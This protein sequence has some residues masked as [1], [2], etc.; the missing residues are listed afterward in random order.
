MKAVTNV[1]IVLPDK[2]MRDGVV[3]FD[4]EIRDIR[5]ISDIDEDSY[6]LI[7]G[8]GG[9]LTP[10]LIDIHI[11]GSGGNDTMEGSQE[12]LSNISQTVIE[13]GVTSFLPTT[14]TMRKDAIREAL[15]SI[16]R[17]MDNGSDG[18][19]ILGTH[20]EGPFINPDYK[21]AQAEENIQ[22]PT[23]ELVKDFLDIIKI[24]TLAPEMEGAGEFIEYISRKGV[25]ASI[26]HS[27][28]TFSQAKE[29]EKR[30]LDH[31][32]HLFNAMTGLHH[33][34]PGIVGAVLE[35]E[36]TCELIADFIHIRPE[37]LRLVTKTKDP[38]KI[39]LISDAMEA[40]GL[41]DGEYLLGGQKVYVN[42]G[43]ARLADGTLAGSV[44]T[45]D[46]ALRNMMNT[47]DLPLYKIVN[48]V[49]A[50]PAQRLN[51]DHKIGKIQKGLDADLVLFDKEF[52]VKQVFVKGERKV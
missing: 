20:M 28:A 47:A 36:M 34:K 11:H 19:R 18:A 1:N 49:T 23:L 42:D 37:V 15:S 45:L 40:G 38:D 35:G 44:L 16:K 17:A 43:E 32:A 4:E 6:E 25:V 5:R 30:G 2:I 50:N 8:K 22:Q 51:I 13:H 21:G 39:I 24:I 46:Q 33:R 48:M 41:E 26:G 10:G 14:M 3:I 7:D 12:S 27:S 31:A 29:A 52:S 9:Y